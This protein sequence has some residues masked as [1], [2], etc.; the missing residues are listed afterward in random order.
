MLPVIGTADQCVKWRFGIEQELTLGRCLIDE[1][2]SQSRRRTLGKLLDLLDRD[3]HL[4]VRGHRV[5]SDRDGRIRHR[6][7][8]RG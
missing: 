2:D 7:L 8:H 5:P 3:G 6:L 1:F 4:P